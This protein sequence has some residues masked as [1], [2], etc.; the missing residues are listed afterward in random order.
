MDVEEQKRY[1]QSLHQIEMQFCINRA[2]HGQ[3]DLNKMLG[4]AKGTHQTPKWT[5]LG[6]QITEN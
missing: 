2:H 5:P 1:L 3:I 4:T 6:P